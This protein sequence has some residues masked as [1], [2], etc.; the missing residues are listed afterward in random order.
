MNDSSIVYGD[1]WRRALAL[2]LDIVFM[3]ICIVAFPFLEFILILIM[4]FVE[5]KVYV[6]VITSSISGKLFFAFIFL[7]SPLCESSKIQG[8]LGKKL[9][10]VSV[11]DHQYQRIS[12]SK[13]I[14]RYL[15][16]L[17]SS[18]ILYIGFLMALPS[19]KRLTLHDRLAKTYVVHTKSLQQARREWDREHLN[20][21]QGL[22]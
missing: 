7:Y 10:G 14:L 22:A 3:F 12:F 11:V 13:A 19:S 18:L 4:P 9:M 21:L 17:I 15:C 8:T 20:Q 16:R 1:F 5:L 2:L 6:M